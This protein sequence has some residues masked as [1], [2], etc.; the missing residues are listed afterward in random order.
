M[1]ANI[2]KTHLFNRIRDIENLSKQP[3]Q[4][5]GLFN[6]NNVS[7]ISEYI[8]A[9][10]ESCF[11]YNKINSTFDRYIATVLHLYKNDSSFRD[12]LINSKGFCLKHY[13]MLYSAAINKLN[14]NILD[15]FITD[16]NTVTIDNLKRVD[17]DLNWYIDKFDYRYKDEPWKN[18]KDA[19]ERTILKVSSTVF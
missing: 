6:K 2:L 11:I 18:S 4:K 3:Y 16:L 7:P 9:H 19:I 10:N 5:S 12:K 13:D 14:K 8:H 17:S 1:L 15:S